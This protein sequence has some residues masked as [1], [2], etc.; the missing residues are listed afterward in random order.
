MSAFSVTVE[1]KTFSVTVSA[2]GMQGAAGTSG[3]GGDV[4]GPASSVSGNL[5][6]FSGTGGKTLVDSGTSAVAIASAAA[7]ALSSHEALTSGIHGISA[8][9]ATLLDDANAAA[10]RTTLGLGTA[11]TSNTTAFEASGAIATHAAITSGVHGISAFA[12]TL[13]D[14]A[15][16]SAFITTLFGGATG[17]G[18]AVR[19]TSPSFVTPTLGVASATS[20]TVGAGSVSAPSVSVGDL[21]SGIYSHLAGGLSIAADGVQAV[22]IQPDASVAF[23]GPYALFSYDLILGASADLSIARVG[24]SAVGVLNYA[25]PSSPTSF[26]V[27][28]VAGTDYERGGLTWQKVANYLMLVTEAGGVGSN[29]AIWL[30]SASHL[31]FTAG[32]GESAQWYLSTGGNWLASTDSAYTIG[33]DGG[34]RPIDLHLARNL[35]LGMSQSL[36]GGSKV[37]N[38]GNC[39]TAPTTN[40]TG[41][42][43]L[44]VEAGALKYRGTS[45][46]VTTIAPA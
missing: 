43:I 9:V 18:N 39:T 38:I 41:G 30:N 37:I 31:Y 14:D 29:R 6:A 17:T 44:Y 19:A 7:V 33:G 25:S 12:A 36:G 15:N 20:L 10:F 21:N 8:F 45:G 16:A 11:A 23:Y 24:I 26:S 1:P 5:P 3:G 2:I 35:V 4:T 28:N 22:R 32:G 42:G 46:T 13:L 34:N 40:P 27:Y